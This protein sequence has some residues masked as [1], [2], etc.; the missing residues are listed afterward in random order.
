[1]KTYRTYSITNA[2]SS[3]LKRM[4]RIIVNF[5]GVLGAEPLGER[6]AQDTATK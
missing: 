5:N 2:L 4:P 6:V 1:M 3:Q